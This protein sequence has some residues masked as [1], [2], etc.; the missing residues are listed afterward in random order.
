V[1]RQHLIRPHNQVSRTVLDASSH[2]RN[3]LDAR[4]G[5]NTT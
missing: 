4:V 1:Q 3:D 5:K 2:I